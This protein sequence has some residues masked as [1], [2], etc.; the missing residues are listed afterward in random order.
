MCFCPIQSCLGSALDGAS[1]RKAEPGNLPS[2]QH[3]TPIPRE[4]ENPHNLEPDLDPLL[5]V[6]LGLF[7][8]LWASSVTLACSGPAACLSGQ[9]STFSPRILCLSNQDWGGA[10]KWPGHRGLSPGQ[11]FQMFSSRVGS[12]PT[13][14]AAWAGAPHP[15]L[16]LTTSPLLLLIPS[17]SVSE[18]NRE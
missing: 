6:L 8:V 4:A 14:S 16:T 3:S 1:P 9:A 12:I 10:G 18:C 13:G 7:I 2:G 5:R 11:G 15:R 17:K